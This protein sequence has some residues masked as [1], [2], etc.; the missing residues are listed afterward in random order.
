MSNWGIELPGYECQ[1]SLQCCRGLAVVISR[2]QGLLSFFLS[3]FSPCANHWTVIF[4]IC[5]LCHPACCIVQ[6]IVW[7]SLKIRS[8]PS[9][10]QSSH[11]MSVRQTPL[12]TSMIS[13]DLSRTTSVTGSRMGISGGVPWKQALQICMQEIWWGGGHRNDVMEQGK[14]S[15]AEGNV[16]V[17]SLTR[18]PM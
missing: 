14:P 16:V 15:R 7:L 12:P 18:Y 13:S 3:T 10:K 9:P 17:R 4:Y 11:G 8:N 1:T 2:C 5:L 6:W